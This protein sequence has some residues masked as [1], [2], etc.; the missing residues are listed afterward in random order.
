MTD[1][2]CADHLATGC[3]GCGAQHSPA[4]TLEAHWVHPERYEEADLVPWHCWECAARGLDADHN[5]NLCDN[6]D[7]S[8]RSR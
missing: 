1:R 6:H 8:L 2:A 4:G 7:E 3:T 5:P